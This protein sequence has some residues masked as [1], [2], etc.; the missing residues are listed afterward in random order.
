VLTLRVLGA[1]EAYDGERAV[2]LGGPRQRS[3]LALLAVAR[4][5]VVAVDRI[6]EGLWRGEPPP[7]AIG[8]LQAYISHLRRAL[9]PGRAARTAAQVLVS[10]APGY[11]LRL[12][13]EQVDAWHFERLTRDAVALLG[14][15]PATAKAAL[16]TALGLWR[17]PAYAEFADEEWAAPEAARL[18]ELRV[19]AVEHR[20]EA[21]LA[22]G[23]A[24]AAVP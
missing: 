1:F 12:E 8:A 20:A 19:V 24:A 7:S 10:A 5:R 6:V 9:E 13:P 15:D 3:V 22:L 14:S 11:A 18:E 4:G 2:E 16:D 23:M 21:A 17:G